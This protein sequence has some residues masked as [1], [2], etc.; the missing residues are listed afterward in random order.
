MVAHVFR[1][2]M[3][4]THLY[5]EATVAGHRCHVL[6]MSAHVYWG[7]MVAANGCPGSTVTA[8]VLYMGSTVTAHVYQGT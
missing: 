8:N 2:S 6:T 4:A 1:E 3:V 5:W 7:S